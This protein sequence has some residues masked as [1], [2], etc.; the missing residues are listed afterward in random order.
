MN[1]DFD[2]KILTS[3]LLSAG[4]IVIL[5][6][7]P[8][9]NPADFFDRTF[10]EYK[11]GFAANGICRKR[12]RQAFSNDDSITGEGWLGLEKM[13]QITSKKMYRLKITLTAR[14]WTEYVGYYDWMKV[15]WGFETVFDCSPRGNNSCLIILTRSRK[16]KRIDSE[17]V[18]SSPATPPLEMLSV[19][20]LALDGRLVTQELPT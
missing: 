13:H 14:N 16:E 8:T 5:C 9:L 20:T 1:C 6:R 18:S 10:E 12:T 4:S 7:N 15:G 17:L 2:P 11:N 3:A 19:L